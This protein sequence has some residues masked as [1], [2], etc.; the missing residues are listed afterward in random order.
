MCTGIM[1]EVGTKKLKSFKRWKHYVIH[2]HRH[3]SAWSKQSVLMRYKQRNIFR[4]SMLRVYHYVAIRQRLSYCRKEASTHYVYR[5]IHTYMYSYIHTH[6]H[7]HTHT[8]A[9][10]DMLIQTCT[11]TYEHIL[12][13]AKKGFEFFAASIHH[14]KRRKFKLVHMLIRTFTHTYL[15]SYI[16]IYIYTYMYTYIL[17]RSNMS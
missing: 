8:R 12:R 3:N 4:E 11:H 16:H 15:H 5:Y 9:Y 10:I 6:T 1:N 14:D 7:T 13:M 2:T 17:I